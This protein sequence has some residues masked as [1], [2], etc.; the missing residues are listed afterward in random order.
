MDCS[1]VNKIIENI[2][3]YTQEQKKVIYE[4]VT[5]IK[6]KKIVSALCE[7]R[8][9]DSFVIGLIL[10]N[11]SEDKYEKVHNKIIRLKINY[12]DSSN[13]FEIE[14]DLINY[15]NRKRIDKRLLADLK[16]FFK[17]GLSSNSRYKIAMILKKY[18][19]LDDEEI[20]SLKFD[21]NYKTRQ[22]FK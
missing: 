8:L 9:G 11:Y 10:N 22:K 3:K 12:S 6:T 15:F 2:N 14:N 7:K 5:K 4:I 16:F 13:W 19:M 1:Y 18:N 20:E 17:N 21:A